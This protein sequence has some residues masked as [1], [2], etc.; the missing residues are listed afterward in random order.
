M[1]NIHERFMRLALLQAKKAYEKDETP[2]GC[3]ITQ[4]NKII[5]RAYNTR[6]T[7]KNALCHAE[8]T[9]IGKAC[10]I[11]GDW[12]LE[13]CVIYVTV[14]PCPMCAGAIIQ[15][16]IPLVVYGASNPKAGCGGSVLNIL[17]HD[18]FNHRAEVVAGVLGGECAE[19]MTRFFKKLKNNT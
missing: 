6:N 2:I 3:I 16:R 7:K 1:Q 14:E 13:D 11:T 9:A 19:L 15:A 5:A 10:K 8:I 17:Q 18:G 12:R 4:N